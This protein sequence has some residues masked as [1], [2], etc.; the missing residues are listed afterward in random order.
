MDLHG[1]G[2]SSISSAQ[3]PKATIRVRFLITTR[4]KEMVS[5]RTT[6]LQ[7]I[8]QSHL[9]ALG[10]WRSW[11]HIDQQGSFNQPDDDVGNVKRDKMEAE[12]DVGRTN[13]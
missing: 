8:A 7:K 3:D 13:P 9:L 10:L 5:W 4:A 2:M 6:I 11:T 12:F 1:I